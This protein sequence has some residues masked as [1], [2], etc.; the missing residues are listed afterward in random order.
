MIPNLV[1]LNLQVAMGVTVYLVLYRVYLRRWFTS[2]PFE[3]VILPLLILHVFRY[4]GLL[5]LAPGQVD[6]ALP[7][8]ALAV[9]AW[10]DFASGV[11]AMI[12]AVAVHHRWSAATLLVGIFSLVG[13]ADFVIVGI[14][15]TRVGIF[16]A[17]IGIMWFLAV[18]FAPA[19][20]L[21][22]I[23]VAYRLIRRLGGE[24][25]SAAVGAPRR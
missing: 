21:S 11:T 20:L 3:V 10:G 17:E 19:L 12:A 23:Y 6:P 5:L 24:S 15:A 14:T 18:F 8:E 9:I 25:P 16:D 2:Q 7:A 1:V 4:L 22:Q 13:L